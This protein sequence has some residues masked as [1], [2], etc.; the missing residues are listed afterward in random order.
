VLVSV[1]QDVLLGVADGQRMM[2]R[3][4]NEIMQRL[5]NNDAATERRSGWSAAIKNRLDYIVKQ[6]G[7]MGMCV[8]GAGA[9]GEGEQ[10]SAADM[11]GR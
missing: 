11:E 1:G 5:D 10:S 7:D 9:E 2:L 6:L 3:N 8:E 4:Q